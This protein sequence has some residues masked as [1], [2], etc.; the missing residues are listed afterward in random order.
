MTIDPNIPLRFKDYQHANVLVQSSDFDAAPKAKFLYHVVFELTDEAKAAFTINDNTLKQLSVLAKTASLPSYTANVET[1]NQYNRKK[2]YQTKIEYKDVNISFYDD[3]AGLSRSLLERYYKYYFKEST[4]AA[5][6][7]I[8]Y[9]DKF[10]SFLLPSYGLDNGRTKPFFEY[11]K[12]FQLSKQKWFCYT[13]VNPIIT[14]WSHDELSY[15]EGSAIT[16]NKIA[17]GY[18]AVLYTKGTITENGDPAGFTQAWYD[19]EVVPGATY[20]TQGYKQSIRTDVTLPVQPES[21]RFPTES[22]PTASLD[23]SS[24]R[25]FGVLKDIVIPRQETSI[26]SAVTS[27]QTTAQKYDATQLQTVISS[28]K[29]MLDALT[30]QALATGAYSPEWNS[31]N[32]SNFKNLDKSVQ[33]ALQTDI[34]EKISTNK[35]IQQLANKITSNNREINQSLE[36]RI[37]SPIARNTSSLTTGPASI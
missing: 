2:K 29:T 22:R 34:V 24:S 31:S 30:T 6:T 37:S 8:N 17:I 19:N 28:N 23:T 20:E 9:R 14:Q 21:A 4:K 33:T 18:E 7:D 1:V 13:L 27:S 26:S 10:S 5:A 16:E 15:S 11:I 12:I 36:N 32:F 3:N 35:K 25:L